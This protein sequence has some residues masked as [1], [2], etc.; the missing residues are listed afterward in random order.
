MTLTAP[1]RRGLLAA[2]AMAVAYAAARSAASIPWLWHPLGE[3]AGTHAA[4]VRCQSYNFW[5]GISGSNITL[6][7][8]AGA[9]ALAWWHQHNCHVQGC[10][11]LQWHAH[12]EHGHPVCK[13]HHPHDAGRL[14]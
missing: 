2:V 14:A 4:V 7:V 11:R 8:A 10:P 1:I 12:P 3:C 13:A 9:Y 5:S 6:P